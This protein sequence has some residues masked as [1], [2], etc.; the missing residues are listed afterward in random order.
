MSTVC[1]RLI[2]EAAEGLAGDGARSPQ[3]DIGDGVRSLRIRGAEAL[4]P[5]AAAR[6]LASAARCAAKSATISA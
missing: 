1:D 4:A 2:G 3:S 5:A 6:S